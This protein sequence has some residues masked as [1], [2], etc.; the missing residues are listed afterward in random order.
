MAAVSKSNDFK[1]LCAGEN[2]KRIRCTPNSHT[3]TGLVERTI[4]SI[5]SLTRASLERGLTFEESVR[6]AIKTF[7]QTP[8][9]KL[10]MTPFTNAFRTEAAHGDYQHD[11]PTTMPSFQLEENCDQI[12][13]SATDGTTIIH[14][15]WPRWR[16]GWLSCHERQQEKIS[17]GKPKV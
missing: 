4:R 3:G 6:S 12:Y 2:I 13:F 10:N 7:R 14:D 11:W 1:E 15:S 8:H 5:K 17:F 9:S 16:D